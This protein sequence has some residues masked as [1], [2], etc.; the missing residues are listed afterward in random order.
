MKY[1]SINLYLKLINCA[2]A[3]GMSR[4]DFMD[5][6]TSIDESEDLKVIA[7]EEFLELHEMLDDQLGPGFGV[8]VGQEMIIE[9][10]GVLG[11]SWRTVRELEK[12]LNVVNVILNYSQTPLYGKSRKK[13][14]FLR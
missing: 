14:M 12:S 8:R 11:L 13:E 4:N 1:F 7:A 2:I 9:D 5:L 6:P 3:E 10:Y